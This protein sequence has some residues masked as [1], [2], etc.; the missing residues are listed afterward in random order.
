[1]KYWRAITAFAALTVGDIITTMFP[2]LYGHGQI[3]W[4]ANPLYP[5]DP[6]SFLV[7]KLFLS[8]VG[9]SLLL[10][11]RPHTL[12]ILNAFLALVVSWNLILILIGVLS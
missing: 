5:E 1:M 10:V 6:V 7:M 11:W 3:L 2:L 4:E 9:A 12:K 8:V